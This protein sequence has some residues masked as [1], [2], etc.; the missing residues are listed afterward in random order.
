MMFT[1]LGA[2][3]FIGRKLTRALATTAEQVDA[4]HF[5]GGD[6]VLAELQGR[7][8]GHVFYCIGL[9]ANFR[10]RPFDT[11]EAHVCVLR[12]ILEGTRFDSLTYLSSTRVYEGATT[13]HETTTLQVSPD[14]PGHLYNLSKLM[15]ESLCLASGRPAKL[16][17]LSNVFGE[18]M[19]HDSFLGQVL[20]EAT[21]TGTVH[22]LTT[23]DSAKDYV[24]VEDVVRWLPRIAL[25][26][27]HSVYNLASGVNTSNADIASLLTQKGVE[28]SFATDAIQ[29]AFP[30]IDTTRL[31]R[32]F[33]AAQ[34]SLASDFDG[35]YNGFVK[36]K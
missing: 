8:L 25:H 27:S 10:T 14:N 29:W 4:P 35:L 13:T 30:A 32:E 24:A 31:I 23:P 2:R 19:G 26:G 3:G 21:H 7:N 20:D 12:R 28:V 34:N 1:V 6:D 17:R 16:V 15:G 36:S 33:G 22:L 9:T 11:V 5:R 18:G